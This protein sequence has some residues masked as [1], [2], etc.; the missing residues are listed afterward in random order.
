MNMC[1]FVQT[2]TLLVVSSI[3]L[4]SQQLVA[5]WSETA[6]SHYYSGDRSYHIVSGAGE[7]SDGIT[8]LVNDGKS[9][10]TIS[11]SNQLNEGDLLG[12]LVGV[13]SNHSA[14]F[15]SASTSRSTVINSFS[16]ISQNV[17]Q[18]DTVD[19]LHSVGMV[20]NDATLLIAQH[21]SGGFRLLRKDG[22]ESALDSICWV[23]RPVYTDRRSDRYYTVDTNNRIT[24]RSINT[25]DTIFSFQLTGPAS[26]STIRF[27]SVDRPRD[28]TYI[29]I[30][31]GTLICYNEK[32]SVLQQVAFFESRIAAVDVDERT[33]YV[34]VTTPDSVILFRSDSDR[35]IFYPDRFTIFDVF[36]DATFGGI[37]NTLLI[38]NSQFSEWVSIDG[39][40]SSRLASIASTPFSIFRYKEQIVIFGS[41]SRAH[42]INYGS[43]SYV[44]GREM[45]LFSLAFSSSCAVFGQFADSALHFY[46]YELNRNESIPVSNHAGARC[47]GFSCSTRSAMFLNGDSVCLHDLRTDRCLVSINV[48]MLGTVS[49]GQVDEQNAQVVL[50]GENGGLIVSDPLS[51]SI[52]QFQP[53]LRTRVLDRHRRVLP[54]NFTVVNSAVLTLYSNQTIA[55][56]NPPYNTAN[57]LTLEDASASIR[58]VF[59]EEGDASLLIV[60]SKSHYWCVSLKDM[61]M[62]FLDS[63][64]SNCLPTTLDRSSA[65][66]LNLISSSEHCIHEEI[67]GCSITSVVGKAIKNDAES[68]LVVEWTGTHL[69]VNDIEGRPISSIE[70]FDLSGRLLASASAGA[71]NQFML[72]CNVFAGLVLVRATGH[73]WQQVAPVILIGM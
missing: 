52:S 67:I 4:F 29:A 31:D 14:V 42:S 64:R 59:F 20:L 46:D 36:T 70:V 12:S 22:P 15:F 37:Q 47:L 23:A 2:F 18:R 9:H 25:C 68:D 55:I 10:V 28:R 32:Q 69:L 27:I 8:I 58:G 11:Q 45:G 5:T 39:T 51:A 33:G 7:L 19:S 71:S 24:V 56:A 66:N 1:R 54:N 62:S 44:A 41:G 16:M 60:D 73:N 43:R 50:T 65:E 30:D 34:V 13:S 48:S 26:L 72:D 21:H 35:K 6:P 40:E 3:H 49:A 61:T 63:S 38:S 53:L 57:L 17:L